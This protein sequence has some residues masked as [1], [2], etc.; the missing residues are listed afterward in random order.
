MACLNTSRDIIDYL[1]AFTPV[2]IAGF[3]AWIALRQMQTARRKLR[4]DLY[5][6]R[7]AV[8]ERTV[9]IYQLLIR[10]LEE[11]LSETFEKTFKEFIVASR[12]S[13]ILF[14]KSSGIFP[15]LKKFHAK[16]FKVIGYKQCAPELKSTPLELKK[17]ADEAQDAIAFFEGALSKED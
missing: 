6:R 17:C 11:P 7:F 15:L 2:A 12:E 13:Q 1:V 14:E 8:Y 5:Q 16:T 9:A 4:L 10:P 3:A